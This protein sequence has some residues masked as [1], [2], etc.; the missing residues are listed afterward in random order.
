MGLKVTYLS[1]E[2]KI[3]AEVTIS[4]ETFMQIDAPHGAIGRVRGGL[5]P[6][7]WWYIPE[8]GIYHHSKLTRKG[9]PGSHFAGGKRWQLRP[10]AT[11]PDV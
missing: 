5:G 1:G 7:S 9:A 3:R 10:R 8:S 11:S 2:D 4:P 6:R